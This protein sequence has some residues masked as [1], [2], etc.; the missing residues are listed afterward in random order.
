[1][2]KALAII[3]S[4]DNDSNHQTDWN[5]FANPDKCTNAADSHYRKVT[6][7]SAGKML[8]E[9]VSWEWF[10]QSQPSFEL[11]SVVS[12]FAVCTLSFISFF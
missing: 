1:M 12:S 9:H 5:T 8:S 2:E 10:K 4:S 11:N 7:Y 6:V 3:P